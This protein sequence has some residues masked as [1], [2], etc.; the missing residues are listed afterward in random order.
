MWDRATGDPVY[1][2]IVWQDTRTQPIVD[3]IARGDTDRFKEKVGLPL[4]TYFS[5]TKIAWILENVE[6]A[7]ARAEA[8]ELAFGTTDS[9]VLWNLTGGI[10]GGV[11]ATDVTNA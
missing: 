7:R 10:H 5:G 8:G 1:N 2:A 11:H 6:G 9:W 3:R 4:A